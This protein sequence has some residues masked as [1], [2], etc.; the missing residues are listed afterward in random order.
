MS[1]VLGAEKVRALA[2]W[3]AELQREHVET[4]RRASLEF[5]EHEARS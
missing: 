4:V 1:G 2:D 3:A 5:A